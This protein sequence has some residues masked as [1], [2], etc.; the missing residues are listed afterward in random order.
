MEQEINQQ[1][2]SQPGQ[3][4]AGKTKNLI[5]IGAI[6]SILGALIVGAIVYI[7]LNNSY[8]E[9]QTQLNNQ[10]SIL[11][12]QIDSLKKQSETTQLP[13]VIEQD[14]TNGANF[15]PSFTNNPAVTSCDF[16]KDRVYGKVYTDVEGSDAAGTL[17][18]KG[19]I[20]QRVENASWEEGK[21]VTKVYLVFSDPINPSQQVFYDHY[22]KM[23]Q[24][25]NL[26]NRADGQQLL[27]SLGIKENSELTTDADISNELK[28]RLISFI[29]KTDII[30]LK[31]TIPV[32]V[33]RS[34]GDESCFACAISE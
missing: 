12:N 8:S 4:S 17:A 33:G 27:F 3:K 7:V 6:S 32:Y 30:Q 9:K 25:G 28:D 2:F 16:W 5:F 15:I 20:I 34:G 18:I 22:L 13:S 11:Q 23:A 31:F 14:Q 19:R 24:G 29:D 21:K 10:I 26:I 1:Q